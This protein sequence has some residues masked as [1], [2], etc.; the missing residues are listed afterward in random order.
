MTS[1]PTTSTYTLLNTST[2]TP[3]PDPSL[4]VGRGY[5]PRA[6]AYL[7]DNLFLLL[8]LYGSATVGGLFVGGFYALLGHEPGLNG[9][10]SG[11]SPSLL[12]LVSFPLYFVLCE[13]IGGATVGKLLMGLRVVARDGRPCGLGAA[14]LRAIIRPFDGILWG[15]PA[16]LSMREPL[17]QRLGDRAAGTFVV[18][19]RSPHLLEA[20]P[21]WAA[22]LTIAVWTVLTFLGLTAVLL[23]A[24]A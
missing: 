23:L 19:A 11:V 9:E 13:G 2:P 18:E 22:P 8:V 24:A 5:W 20:R 12:L 21:A 15:L 16:V 10:A 3:E 1:E 17:N 4:L 6:G 14:L 7:I